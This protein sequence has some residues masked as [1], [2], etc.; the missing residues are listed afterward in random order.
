MTQRNCYMAFTTS[1]FSATAT[2]VAACGITAATAVPFKTFSGDSQV[3]AAYQLMAD[4]C[5]TGTGTATLS[6]QECIRVIASGRR[7]AQHAGPRTRTRRLDAAQLHRRAR[8]GG[9]VPASGAGLRSSRPA[10]SAGCL[11]SA[12]RRHHTA[13]RSRPA[14]DIFL[15]DVPAPLATFRQS[16]ALAPELGERVRA[17]PV[18]DDGHLPDV[19]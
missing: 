17:C 5:P 4:A 2:A 11:L 16:F 14:N 8:R 18:R 19:P 7:G 9:P 15:L 6:T 12:L 10:L 3:S 13:H 1:S